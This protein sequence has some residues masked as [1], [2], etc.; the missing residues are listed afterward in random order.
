MT[1]TCDGCQRENCDEHPFWDAMQCNKCT[2]FDQYESVKDRLT[3]L[4]Y[5]AGITC[6]GASAK[7]EARYYSKSTDS[8]RIRIAS[9]DSPYD[10]SLNCYFISIGKHCYE[11]NDNLPLDADDA[12]IEVAAEDAIEYIETNERAED[13]ARAQE[14]DE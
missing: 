14:E 11:E 12:L 13:E 2:E 7:S 3:S 1:E 8:I 9:H 10:S 5:E 4:L 6:C